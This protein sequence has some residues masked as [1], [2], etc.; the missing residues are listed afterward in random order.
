MAKLIN[1]NNGE[2]GKLQQNASQFVAPWIR[3]K[4]F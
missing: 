2:V 3:G 1:N 4:Y